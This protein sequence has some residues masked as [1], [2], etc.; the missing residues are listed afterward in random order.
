MLKTPAQGILQNVHGGKDFLNRTSFAKELRST[1]VKRD[2]I[3]L[4]GFT[5]E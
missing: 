2:F 3:K 4:K 1:V 5:A